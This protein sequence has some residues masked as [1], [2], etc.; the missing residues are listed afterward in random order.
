MIKHYFHQIN[1]E[2]VI[3][4]FSAANRNNK[5]KGSCFI[6]RGHSDRNMLKRWRTNMTS[7]VNQ[8]GWIYIPRSK[9]RKIIKAAKKI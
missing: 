9:A 7:W 3:Y 2:N 1:G 5:G 6:I 4:R 8:D